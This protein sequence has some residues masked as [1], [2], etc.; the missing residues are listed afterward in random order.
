MRNILIGL[1]GGVGKDLVFGAHGV[2]LGARDPVRTEAVRRRD[3]AAR[4]HDAPVSQTD[5]ESFLTRIPSPL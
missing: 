2:A 3:A 4:E 1:K 5:F